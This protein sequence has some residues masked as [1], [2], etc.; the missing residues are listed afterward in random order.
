[1]SESSLKQIYSERLAELHAAESQ[2]VRA[3]PAMAEAAC[4]DRVKDSLDQQLVERLNQVKRLEPLMEANDIKPVKTRCPE[5]REVFSETA[6]LIE[7]EPDLELVD[8]GLVA[9]V[10]K[11]VSFYINA[12]GAVLE[13][14]EI[15]G[16][17]EALPALQQ[18]LAEEKAAFETFELL[19]ARCVP[20]KP[21]AA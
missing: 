15:L 18:S 10:E 12:Y 6:Y 16:D 2:F 19:A 3:L 5:L 13:L 9:A 8:A 14:A 1:M 17:K 11:A 21:I 20:L 4:S 7:V